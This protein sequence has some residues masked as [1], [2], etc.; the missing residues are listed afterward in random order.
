V[1]TAVGQDDEIDC[2]QRVTL[3]ERS[4]RTMQVIVVGAGVLGVSVAR[5]LAA[6]GEDVLLLDQSG[7]GTGTTATTFAWTNSSRKHDPDYHR[8]NLAGMAEHARLAERLR[9]AQAY[10]PS[11]ALQWADTSNEQW[12]L[13]LRSTAGSAT[14]RRPTRRS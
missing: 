12:L 4:V 14:D 10:F 9:G 2:E 13:R 8:L 6:G 7:V 3:P 5:Q 11:G 1:S